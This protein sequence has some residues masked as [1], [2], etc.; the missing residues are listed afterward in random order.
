MGLFDFLKSKQKEPEQLPD[1]LSSAQT[2]TPEMATGSGEFSGL[3]Q[4]PLKTDQPSKQ[5]SD[6]PVWLTNAPQAAPAEIKSFGPY[7]EQK[8]GHP[9]QYS[10]TLPF[11]KTPGINIQSDVLVDQEREADVR[12]NGKHIEVL[13]NDQI[14]GTIDDPSKAKMVSDWEKKGF[15]CSAIILRSCTEVV[16]RFYRDKRLGNE[17]RPQ[18]VFA[19]IAYKSSSKQEMILSLSSGDELEFEEDWDHE[20]SVIV[21]CMGEPIGKLPKKYAEKYLSEGAH[22]VYFEKCE[23]VAD[24]YDYIV[25]PFIRIYW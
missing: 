6:L 7:P 1:W 23:E 14:I 18:D 16:L 10:Y 5:P 22:S 25:K 4:N 13:F 11:T 9:L 20:N 3:T 17:W 24:E 21:L 19:L 15:P 8:E 2:P 12:A